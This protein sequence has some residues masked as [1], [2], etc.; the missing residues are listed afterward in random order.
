MAT[1]GAAIYTGL[2]GGAVP[3][4]HHA[5]DVASW[6]RDQDGPVISGVLWRL[7]VQGGAEEAA[8]LGEGLAVA[9]S[10]KQGLLIN[11]HMEAWL[12]LVR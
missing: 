7:V 10:R 1:D 4:G 6:S 12:S 3:E 2:L 11:P 5:V 8:R 9:R